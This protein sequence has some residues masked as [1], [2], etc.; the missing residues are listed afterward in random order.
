MIDYEQL[1]SIDKDTRHEEREREETHKEN[2]R[3]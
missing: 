3:D 2:I 1:Q